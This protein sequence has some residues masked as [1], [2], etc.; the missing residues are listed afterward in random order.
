MIKLDFQA[1]EPAGVDPDF[2]PTQ[3]MPAHDEPFMVALPMPDADA[4]WFSAEPVSLARVGAGV[5]FGCMVMPVLL[6]LLAG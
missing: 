2:A 5:F 1:T 6:P 3:P 4:R